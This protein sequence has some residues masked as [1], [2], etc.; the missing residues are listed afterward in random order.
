M[1]KYERIPE[2]ILDLHGYTLREAEQELLS[3][4]SPRKYN[5]VR[6]VT[7][8]GTFRETGPV[9]KNFVRDFLL[10]RNIAYTPA[11]LQHGGE[12]AYEVFFTRI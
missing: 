9:L 10:A 7:G 2:Y 12:G 3:V 6:V 8:K 11:K 1:N 5:H 4:I